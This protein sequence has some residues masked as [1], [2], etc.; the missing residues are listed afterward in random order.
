MKE[1]NCADSKKSKEKILYICLNCGIDC[2]AYPSQFSKKSKPKFCSQKCKNEFKIKDGH[3]RIE[4]LNCGKSKRVLKSSE[5]KFCTTKCAG[6][7]KRTGIEDKCLICG[8]DIYY[9]P[10]DPKK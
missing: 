9:F 10:S 7:F 3:N 4:C 2:Y 8:K 5:T 1:E 6:E